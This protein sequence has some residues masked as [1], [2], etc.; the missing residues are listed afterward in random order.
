M[1][2]PLLQAGMGSV[3]EFEVGGAAEWQVYLLLAMIVAL[4][5]LRLARPQHLEALWTAMLS[6]KL[7]N[8]MFRKQE[9]IEWPSMLL[10]LN[11]I[12]LASL[13]ASQLMFSWTAVD[14]GRPELFLVL[15]GVFSAVMLLRLVVPSSLAGL[16]EARDDQRLYDSH[17]LMVLQVLGLVL[18]PLVVIATVV[19]E[20]RI[21]MGWTVLALAGC[22]VIYL[23]MRGLV[24]AGKHW[25]SRPVHFF[26]YFCA[27]YVAPVLLVLK[28]ASHYILET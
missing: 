11:T 23:W 2:T 17:M 9:R 4:A 24:I 22:A 6:L 13:F 28:A 7:A 14:L 10:M 15:I 1:T 3:R 5:L 26:L 21:V 8:Q 20:T 19:S 18:L 27:L 16:F 25:S 12:T